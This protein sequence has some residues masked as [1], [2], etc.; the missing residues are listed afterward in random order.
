MSDSNKLA[1]VNST[2]AT[3]IEDNS[4]VIAHL[5][6]GNLGQAVVTQRVANAAAA[7]AITG[8]FRIVARAARLAGAVRQGL[9]DLKDLI[10]TLA[11]NDAAALQ[12]ELAKK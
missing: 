3:T 4:E 1:M 5:D 12:I 2:E 11:P 10:T 8:E 7:R 6:A 9:I